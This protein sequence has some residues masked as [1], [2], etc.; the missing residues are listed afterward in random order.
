MKTTPVTHK[1]VLTNRLVWLL[2]HC[3]SHSL[4]SN[5]IQLL[6]ELQWNCEK[7]KTK[8]KWK[9]LPFKLKSLHAAAWLVESQLLRWRLT[10]SISTCAVYYRSASISI[11][12][13]TRKTTCNYRRSSSIQSNLYEIFV[14]HL[15]CSQPP[16]NIAYYIQYGR[17]LWS[18]VSHDKPQQRS[19]EKQPRLLCSWTLL[20]AL[21]V[22]LWAQ[23]QVSGHSE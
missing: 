9:V 17:K 8:R 1:C 23:S 22:T 14:Q 4:S 10:F 6:S 3:C 7:C 15:Y 13:R 11:C 20:N 18:N 16:R 12:I 2:A 5:T 19:V 21:S